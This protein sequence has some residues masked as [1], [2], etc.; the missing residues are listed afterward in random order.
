MGDV[1]A[2]GGYYISMGAKK[3]YA[4]PGTLTGSIGVVG[5]K[6]ALNGL[7]D[8]VGI[9]T[10]VISRGKNSG[11]QSIDEPFSPI[12]SSNA[13]KKMMKEIYDQF[14]TK[15]AEG[16]KLDKAKLQE[17]L[18]GGRVYS[19]KQAVDNKLVDGSARSTTP[20]PRPKPWPA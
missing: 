8:K 16:R 10:D 1:A 6:L 18:A 9:T 19:G 5:G 15:A 14:T 13:W 2:S 20:W 7:F 11:R 4:E 12:R 3:I 17:S